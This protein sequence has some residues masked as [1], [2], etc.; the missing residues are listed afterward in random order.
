MTVIVEPEAANPADSAPT[1]PLTERYAPAKPVSIRQTIGAL[2]RGPYDPTQI[3]AGDSLWRTFRTPAGAATLRIRQDG[4][5][6][7][8]QA[9]GPGAAW[10]IEGVP[11]L[12]GARDD[13]STLDVGRHPL[14]RDSAR[15]NL[16]LR[17]TRTRLVFEALVP[18]VIEQRVTSIEAYRSWTRLVRRFGEVAPGPAPDGLYVIP[19]AEQWRRV[20]SWEW[21]RAGVDPGRSRAILL[22]AVVAASLERT[23]DDAVT[24]AQASTRIRSV[25]GIGIWTAAET[26]QRSHGDPDAVSVGDYHLAHFVGSALTG[27]RVDDDGMLELLEPWAGQRQ[28]VI[29]LLLAS[30]HRAPR[31]GPRATIQDHRGH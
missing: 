18:A 31:F 15:R 7:V 16:G 5:A 19:T 4:A 10:V 26:M 22:A 6:V 17:L 2:G 14:V 29:R 24:L 9:W 8:A 25:P 13:W 11:E 27:S 3:W 21:H 23:L 28:R 12:L 20:P 1:A 30:G